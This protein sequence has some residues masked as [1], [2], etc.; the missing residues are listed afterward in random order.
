[1]KKKTETKFVSPGVF[2]TDGPETYIDGAA[3]QKILAEIKE[4]VKRYSNDQELGEEIRRYA[5]SR[6]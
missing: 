6:L 2:T 4:L 5:S 1:M 3:L